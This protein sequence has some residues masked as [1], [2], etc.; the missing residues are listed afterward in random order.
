MNT[1]Q[2]AYFL[3][4]IAAALLSIFTLHIIISKKYGYISLAFC[5][6]SL[7]FF[8]IPG[9]L[10]TEINVFPFYDM[11]YQIELQNQGSFIV[12]LF[13][14]F[15]IVG[16]L[17]IKPKKIEAKN[18]P[19][20]VSKTRFFTAITIL[21]AIQ[22]I[23]LMIFGIDSFVT[24]RS[25]FD[26]S[27][28][29]G[30]SSTASV[31]ISVIRS[32]SFLSIFITVYFFT[33]KKISS[34]TFFTALIIVAP[35]F[36][37]INYPLSLARYTFFAYILA[38]IFILLRPTRLTKT[39]IFGAFTLGITTIFPFFTY[40]TRS[41]SETFNID[42]IDYYRTS[43]DF[44][45]YQSLLNVINLVNDHGIMYGKQLLGAIFI[46]VP[47]SIWTSK[48]DP[49]GNFAAEHIGYAFT[50]ISAPLVS[51]LYI[52]F[53]IFGVT[54]LS[55]ILGAF[56]RQLDFESIWSIKNEDSRKT[57]VIGLIFSFM[58]IVLRGSLM[59]VVAGIGLNILLALA[60]TNFITKS[61]K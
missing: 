36:L 34:K 8:L 61:N 46:F 19:E 41:K 59:G 37:I 11:S 53:G 14:L 51:E 60:I 38:F 28:F 5:I 48:P 2:L 25:E 17:F 44:D 55:F 33:I 32:I 15:F 12:L 52:D 21:I 9:I 29:S 7:L 39:I 23:F 40:I 18:Y 43:G 45:G 47:R 1:S 4:V 42:Y 13:V 22:A 56:V 16:F 6:Y 35:L 30:S 26:R 50:N 10:H 24:Q 54:I 31:I 20:L 27:Q 49:T 57:I 3:L 58:I